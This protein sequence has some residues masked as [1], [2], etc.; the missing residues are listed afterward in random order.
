MLILI[1]DINLLN[2]FNA[3]TKKI[4]NLTQTFYKQNN[5]LIKLKDLLLPKL[6]TGKIRVNLEDMKES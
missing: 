2:K 5:I 4:F 1:P 6:I 3:I